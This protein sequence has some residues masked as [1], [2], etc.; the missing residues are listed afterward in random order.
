[1]PIKVS[2]Y[3]HQIVVKEVTTVRNDSPSSENFL[4]P[5]KSKHFWPLKRALLEILRRD[6]SAT[7][8]FTSL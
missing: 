7:F 3:N 6:A 8:K 1:M 4:S 2:K 5:S